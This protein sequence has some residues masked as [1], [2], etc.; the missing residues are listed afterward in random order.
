M[1]GKGVLGTA[2]AIILM[3]ASAP[4][5]AERGPSTQEERDKALQ[6]IQMLETDPL[7][8]DAKSAREWLTVWMIEVPDI[9][10]KV[11]GTLLGPVLD[12]KKNYSAELATQLLYSSGAFIIR[13]RGKSLDDEAVYQAGLEGSLRVYEAIL[14][15]K[16]KARWPFLD[17]LIKKR[18]GGQLQDYVTGAMKDCK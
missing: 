16:P 9:S 7:G 1:Y 13:N 12:S 11:C 17:D 2:L 15:S 10:V 6:L 4:S 5:I 8:K 14:K 3:L 18:D